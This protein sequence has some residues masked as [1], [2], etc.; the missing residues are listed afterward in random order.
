VP[1]VEGI[2]GRLDLHRCRASKRLRAWTGAEEPLHRRRRRRRHKGVSTVCESG[3]RLRRSMRF[4]SGRSAARTALYGAALSSVVG[5]GA[6]IF[7][8]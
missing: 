3:G 1:L 4:G 7:S 8:N 2:L 6:T 5:A